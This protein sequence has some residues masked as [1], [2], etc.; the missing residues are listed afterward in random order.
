MSDEKI[1]PFNKTHEVRPLSFAD[2]STWRVDRAPQRQWGVHD[3]FPLK[4]VAL[5]SGE[6]AAGKTLL[7]L[8]LGVAHVLGRDW[9]GTLPRRGPFLYFGAED[10]D[11]EIYR[12]LSD[13]LRHYGVDFPDLQGNFHLLTFVGEDAVL[14]TP[15]HN[16]LIK[17]TPLFLRLMKV[18]GEIKPVLIGID[19]SADVFAGDESNRAQVRQFVGMLRKL[20]IPSNGYVILNS[21]PSQTGI[22]SGTGLS[23]STGWHNTVRSRAYLT[24]V[25]TGKDEEP[26]PNLRMLQFK[27]SNYGPISQSVALRWENGV[28]KLVPGVSSLNKLAA[29]QHVEAIFIQLLQRFEAS[30]RDVSSKPSSIYAPKLF[31]LEAEAEGIGDKALAGAMRRLFKADKIK[32]LIEGPPSRRRQRLVL[33]D[34][35]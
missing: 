16:G 15:D 2:T 10:D 24:T 3:Q 17:P 13:I 28:Y 5:L 19:T 4:N 14:G 32:N 22:S 33:V 8:Q 26:D 21:H 1:A 9:L 31:A 7:M 29:Q 25:R 35:S 18:V 23:G 12:R 11:D 20:A 6:G 27:K 30:G 34:A